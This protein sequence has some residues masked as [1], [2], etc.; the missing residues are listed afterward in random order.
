MFGNQASCSMRLFWEATQ[1]HPPLSVLALACCHSLLE[2]QFAPKIHD[3][4]K[5]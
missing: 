5:W 2:V 1:L 4:M 3:K